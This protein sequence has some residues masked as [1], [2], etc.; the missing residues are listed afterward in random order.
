MAIADPIQYCRDLLF[1]NRK[2]I[3]TGNPEKNTI[4]SGIQKRWPDTTFVHLSNGW[5]LYNMSED[6]QNKLADLFAE[7]TTFIN[8]SYIA[9][10]IQKKLLEICNASTKYYEV[11]NI[12]STHE[13]DQLGPEAYTQSKQEL[14][15]T[16]LNLN[17]FRF[18][19][20]HIMLGGINKQREADLD[21]FLS[22]DEIAETIHWITEQRFKIPL[23][24]IDQPKQS[25]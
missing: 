13:F 24:C 18:Q 6:T 1:E 21:S 7:H 3:C 4:A 16:S 11:F 17:T 23:I 14:Q 10:G 2:I 19:T 5:D 15:K 20:T 22:V 9:P 12:G 25:W 8:A